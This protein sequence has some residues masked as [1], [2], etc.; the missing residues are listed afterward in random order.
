[1]EF[2]SRVDNLVSRIKSDL[3]PI[4]NSHYIVAFARNERSLNERFTFQCE[5][6]PLPGLSYT[7]TEVSYGAGTTRKM[8]STKTFANEIELTFRLSRDMKERLF[9]EEWMNKVCNPKTLIFNYYKNYI[10][11]M[12]IIVQDND[13]VPIYGVV[14]EEVYPTEVSPIEL[15]PA[16]DV[17]K[18]TVKFAYYR[19]QNTNTINGTLQNLSSNFT[20]TRD[21]SLNPW[22][23]PEAV[24]D[25]GRV[26]RYD[27]K[28]FDES[29]RPW[30]EDY[31]KENSSTEMP[32]GRIE[33]NIDSSGRVANDGA[34]LPG[35]D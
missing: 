25:A 4:S 9:F 29:H 7:D 18:Q 19:W 15:T 10:D 30:R 23:Q 17:L 27:P 21:D 24:A 1:M 2:S 3:K 35:S 8:P 26:I 14:F 32:S 5:S 12:S 16:G 31:N 13:D 20:G 33:N 34:V 6:A 11:D 28:E 22:G